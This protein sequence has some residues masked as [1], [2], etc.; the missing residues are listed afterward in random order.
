MSLTEPISSKEKLKFGLEKSLS[1]C[2]LRVK[3]ILVQSR[4]KDL[5]NYITELLKD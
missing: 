3:F 5:E 2:L 1:D 4:G